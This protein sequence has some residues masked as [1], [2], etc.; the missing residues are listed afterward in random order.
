MDMVSLEEL[1]SIDLSKATTEFKIALLEEL[2]F[3]SDGEF[4]TKDGE[5]VKDRYTDNEVRLDNMAILPGKVGEVIIIED[6]VFSIIH[7]QEE[8]GDETV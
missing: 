1:E 3:G 6:G 5:R 4:V 7:Y 2:G 8:F